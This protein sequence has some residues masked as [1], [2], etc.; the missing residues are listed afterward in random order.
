VF[1][2]RRHPRRINSVVK[3]FFMASPFFVTD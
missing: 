3:V 1:A 2:L